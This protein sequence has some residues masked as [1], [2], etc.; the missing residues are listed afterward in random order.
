MRSG[1]EAGA[2]VG[3]LP[4]A[5]AARH[6]CMRLQQARQARPLPGRAAPPAHARAAAAGIRPPARAAPTPAPAPPA[7]RSC[8]AGHPVRVGQEGLEHMRR[9]LRKGAQQRVCGDAQRPTMNAR[10]SPRLPASSPR[11]STPAS[12]SPALCRGTRPRWPAR[13]EGMRT[14]G[15]AHCWWSGSS[16]ASVQQQA[17][18]RRAAIACTR[19]IAKPR[20]AT[21]TQAEHGDQITPA[22]LH[23]L[24][25]A[26]PLI[27]PQL[28][29][30]RQPVV[31]RQQLG[32]V[33]HHCR[34]EGRREDRAAAV[35]VREGRLG[36]AA[37]RSNRVQ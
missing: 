13:R 29:Q 23:Q 4:L 27:L 30:R 15:H 31:A 10:S 36:R 33:V 22:R 24:V 17:S 11:R 14:V 20:I 7:V 21:D 25:H 6:A 5:C 26:L 34:R 8:G 37:W 18:S 28:L 19:C 2:G 16:K 12:H 1:A 3:C 9:Q 35:R 32:I